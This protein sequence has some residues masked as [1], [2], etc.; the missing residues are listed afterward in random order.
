MVFHSFN[1]FR[2]TLL[3]LESRE[4]IDNKSIFSKATILESDF[5]RTKK[6]NIPVHLVEEQ[7]YPSSGV[8][9]A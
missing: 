7:E 8:E 9:F 6:R 4:S 2:M 5:V 3:F 1:P